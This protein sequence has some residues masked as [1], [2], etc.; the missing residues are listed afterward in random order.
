MWK[1][2]YLDE[3]CRLIAPDGNDF[4]KFTIINLSHHTYHE[5]EKQTQGLR[6]AVED[7]FRVVRV[8]CDDYGR[9]GPIDPTARARKVVNYLDMINGYGLKSIITL[10]NF[11]HGLINVSP[12]EKDPSWFE[13]GMFEDGYFDFVQD[14]TIMIKNRSDVIMYQ[15]MNEG[16]KYKDPIG[17]MGWAKTMKD[18]I[19]KI[20]PD[21]LISPGQNSFQLTGYIPPK[22]RDIKKGVT[23]AETWLIKYGK[24][25]IHSFSS[26]NFEGRQVDDFEICKKLNIPCFNFEFGLTP[27]EYKG[28]MTIDWEKHRFSPRNCLNKFGAI[29]LGAWTPGEKYGY[30]GGALDMKEQWKLLNGDLKNAK[31]I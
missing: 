20:D 19:R 15:L 17:Y 1:V 2:E 7:G 21:R 27:P 23:I 9:K 24:D 25:Y 29:S 10:G 30:T 5:R 4:G 16:R 6:L 11:Y 8:F 22:D 14:L 3:K 31:N 12:P 28:I 13:K 26:Y 18:M